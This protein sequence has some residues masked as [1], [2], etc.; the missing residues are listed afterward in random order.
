MYDTHRA[1]L[2]RRTQGHE[3]PHW[4][5]NGE[6]WGSDRLE[7]GEEDEYSAALKELERIGWPCRLRELPGLYEELKKENERLEDKSEA[8]SG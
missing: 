6:V 3:G 7:D 5:P 8:N 1:A 4:S 2:C